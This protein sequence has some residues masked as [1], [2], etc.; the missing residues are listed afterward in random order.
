MTTKTRTIFSVIEATPKDGEPY[1]YVNWHPEVST[2]VDPDGKDT[3]KIL[4]F[5]EELLSSH[6]DQ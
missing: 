4:D 1:F 6:D 2:L 3:D 5:V